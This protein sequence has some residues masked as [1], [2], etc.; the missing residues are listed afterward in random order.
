MADRPSALHSLTSDD[1]SLPKRGSLRLKRVAVQ[2][3]HLLLQ[4]LGYIL[5]RMVQRHH[6]VGHFGVG[7]RSH[8]LV[9]VICLLLLGRRFG[10]VGL[11]TCEY[12]HVAFLQERVEA[13]GT[14]SLLLHGLIV[15]LGTH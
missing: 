4:L 15:E 3:A 9:H 7:W 8:L 2:H 13:E 10:V 11:Q 14:A 5:R 6:D 12:G 1:P